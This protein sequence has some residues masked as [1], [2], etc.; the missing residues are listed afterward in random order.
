MQYLCPTYFPAAQFNGYFQTFIGASW[1]KSR[2]YQ[3]T[4]SC[5]T[6]MYLSMLIPGSKDVKWTFGAGLHIFHVLFVSI[7]SRRSREALGSLVTRD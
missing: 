7:K 2:L 3:S 1:F 5:H 4:E 6:R